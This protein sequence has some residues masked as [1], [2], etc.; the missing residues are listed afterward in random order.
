[1][2][3]SF[4]LS[5]IVVLLV[6][7]MTVPIACGKAKEGESPTLNKGNTWTYKAI[8]NGVYYTVTQQV[9]GETS[10]NARDCWVM[11]TSFEPPLSGVESTTARVDKTNWFTLQNQATGTSA[12]IGFTIA[13][14]IT[15]EA[16]DG[17][18]WPL[19]AGKELRAVETT[20]RTATFGGETE[21][22]TETE[23]VTRK[24][25]AVEEIT[26]P[27]GTFRC[28]RVGKYDESGS[29]F[30][31]YWYSDKVKYWV[32]YVDTENDSTWE[33]KSYSV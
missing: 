16:L 10:V 32:K 23:T 29:K 12:G 31:T 3:R 8:S 15:Y 18:F 25:E 5:A 26:V 28:F 27:A 21:T 9:T 6:V 33:L 1:V 7:S 14:A 19:E 24:I 2:K 13:E 20:R 4:L 11:E 22:E 30:A 17:S